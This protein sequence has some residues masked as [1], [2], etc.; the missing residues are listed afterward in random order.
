[1]LHY[2]CLKIK[3]IT[4]PMKQEPLLNK[5]FD[6]FTKGLFFA[7]P[8]SLVDSVEKSAAVGLFYVHV[9][10]EI[11]ILRCV[12]NFAITFLLERNSVI[13]QNGMPFFIRVDGSVID[14]SLNPGLVA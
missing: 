3:P 8:C 12:V 14:N 6:L 4:Q 1:M 10:S 11:A 7:H 9:I 2:M 13:D 5:F